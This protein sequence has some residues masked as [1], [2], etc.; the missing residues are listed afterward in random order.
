[1]KPTIILLVLLLILVNVSEIKSAL[2]LLSF[3]PSG[4]DVSVSL[5]G[6]VLIDTRVRIELNAIDSAN[7]TIDH[8][9]IDSCNATDLGNAVTNSLVEIIPQSTTQKVQRIDVQH[10]EMRRNNQS[11]GILLYDNDFMTDIHLQE[12]SIMNN[13]FELKNQ[14]YIERSVN[15]LRKY[16]DMIH[17]NLLG[18]ISGGIS[19]YMNTQIKDN[20]FEFYTTEDFL[21]CSSGTVPCINGTQGSSDLQI[22]HHIV[23]LEYKDSGVTSVLLPPINSNTILIENNLWIDKSTIGS[24]MYSNYLTINNLNDPFTMLPITD[25]V[26]IIGNQFSQLNLNTNLPQNALETFQ[27]IYAA[28]VQIGLNNIDHFDVTQNQWNNIGYYT[29]FAYQ[30]V[31]T[32]AN[33]TK[34]TVIDLFESNILIG[35]NSSHNAVFMDNVIENVF[36]TRNLFHVTN[37]RL[38][39]SSMAPLD[40]RFEMRTNTIKNVIFG[41]YAFASDI[42]ALIS[43]NSTFHINNQFN[44]LFYSNNNEQL[45]LRDNI[46]SNVTYECQYHPIPQEPMSMFLMEGNH[47]DILIDDNQYRQVKN[48]YVNNYCP[49]IQMNVDQL[50]DLST[51]IMDSNHYNLTNIFHGVQIEGINNLHNI[52]IRNDIVYVEEMENMGV[53]QIPSMYQIF[54]KEGVTQSRLTVDNNQLIFLENNNMILI[55]LLTWLPEVFKNVTGYLSDNKTA[56]FLINGAS[57]NHMNI[58]NNQIRSHQSD[59]LDLSQGMLELQDASFYAGQYVSDRVTE[60]NELSKSFIWVHLTANVND[61]YMKSNSYHSISTAVSTLPHDIHQ[62]NGKQIDS[63]IHLNGYPFI[64][65]E[66]Y[67]AE[68]KVTKEGIYSSSIVLGQPLRVSMRTGLFIAGNSTTINNLVL[69]YKPSLLME[70]INRVEVGDPLPSQ[71]LTTTPLL[72]L[73]YQSIGASIAKENPELLDTLIYDV[74]V[75]P[76]SMDMYS[77]TDECHY[78]CKNHLECNQCILT[79]DLQ[80]GTIK[81]FSPSSHGVCYGRSVFNTTDN[82]FRDCSHEKLVISAPYENQESFLIGTRNEYNNS[83]IIEP[84]V[85]GSQVQFRMND[86]LNVS[87][88]YET[89]AYNDIITGNI[90]TA[91]HPFI[92]MLANSFSPVLTLLKELQFNHIKFIMDISNDATPMINNVFFSTYIDPISTQYLQQP[93]IMDRFS[94]TNSSFEGNDLDN[95]NN[96]FAYINRYLFLFKP[97]GVG[98]APSGYTSYLTKITRFEFNDNTMDGFGSMFKQREYPSGRFFMNNNYFSRITDGVLSVVVDDTFTINDNVCVECFMN[99]GGSD[100]SILH[101]KGNALTS[102]TQCLNSTFGECHMLRNNFNTSVS[103]FDNAGATTVYRVE[104]IDGTIH[105]DDNENNRRLTYGLCYNDINSSF[106]CSFDGM[107]NLKIRNFDIVGTVKDIIC[108]KGLVTEVSCSGFEC[109]TDTTIDPETCFVNKS[110]EITNPDYGYIQFPTIQLAIDGCRAKNPK[111]IKILYDVYHETS[112]NIQFQDSYINATTHNNETLLLEG[113]S[114]PGTDLKPIIVGNNH[115]IKKTSALNNQGNGVRLNLEIQNLQ[116]INPTGLFDASPGTIGNSINRDSYILSTD[117]NTLFDDFTLNNSCFWAIQTTSTIP[118]YSPTDFQ[119]V[120]KWQELLQTEYVDKKISGVN[121]PISGV[122]TDIV[123][124]VSIK[125][126]STITNNQFYGSYSLG[127]HQY[128]G[129]STSPIALDYTVSKAF[130]TQIN[131]NVGEN[132][133]G[134]FMVLDDQYNVEY[135]STDCTYFCGAYS[136]QSDYTGVTTIDFKNAAPYPTIEISPGVP[137]TGPLYQLQLGN[138]SWV[139]EYGGGPTLNTYVPSTRL[140]FPSVTIPPNIFGGYHAAIWIKNLDVNVANVTDFKIRG[141]KTQG[142]PIALRMTDINEDIIFTYNQELPEFFNDARRFMRETQRHNNLVN[143]IGDMS[144]TIYDVRGRVP[145]ADLA[146]IQDFFCN[147]LCFPDLNQFAKCQVSINHIEGVTT[148]FG[149]TQF[150]N[151]TDAIYRCI[152][153]RIVML[154]LNHYEYI[155]VKQMNYRPDYTRIFP[156]SNELLIE[157]NTGQTTTIYGFNHHFD[158]YDDGSSMNYINKIR[159]K[160]INFQMAVNSTSPPPYN[161]LACSTSDTESNYRFSS[162]I[163]IMPSGVNGSALPMD[164]FTFE[165]VNIIFDLSDGGNE[166]VSI[167]PIINKCPIHDY[168]PHII[169]INCDHCKVRDMTLQNVQINSLVRSGFFYD[170]S[171]YDF[172]AFS[173]RLQEET[174]TTA[175]T[176]IYRPNLFNVEQQISTSMNSRKFIRLLN[177]QSLNIDGVTI[178]LCNPNPTQ[179]QIQSKDQFGKACFTLFSPKITGLDVYWLN[180]TEFEVKITNMAMGSIYLNAPDTSLVENTL[181]PYIGPNNAANNPFYFAPNGTE[182][183]VMVYSGIEWI[184]QSPLLPR[185]NGTNQPINTFGPYETFYLHSAIMN[186]TDNTISGSSSDSQI[187]IGIHLLGPNFDYIYSCTNQTNQSAQIAPIGNATSLGFRDFYFSQ[188]L[189]RILGTQNPDS[190]GIVYDVLFN[191]ALGNELGPSLTGSLTVE[192]VT[193]PTILNRL[194]DNPGDAN[195]VCYYCNDGCPGPTS[196]I[197]ILIIILTIFWCFTFICCIAF[198]GGLDRV[199]DTEGWKEPYQYYQLATK[200]DEEIKEQ[201]ERIQTL[202]LKRRIENNQIFS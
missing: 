161:G 61:V 63:L 91:Y 43:N 157:S 3:S 123:L 98:V 72:K 1:M 104:E 94:I 184:I 198:C 34:N 95:L 96:I 145:S 99:T 6:S 109:L 188:D 182:L 189:T 110:I 86:T 125:R 155:D 12:I 83:L 87:S 111:H 97:G 128:N 197:V 92:F 76:P 193:L 148:D 18:N 36:T 171:T 178:P 60:K 74:Q 176:D 147:D 64:Q 21:P 134:A 40:G 14:R 37:H 22:K 26:T 191:N 140:A 170:M 160:R 28:P 19:G 10:N 31:K 33:I 156:N 4:S 55:P 81:E 163:N 71:D 119:N 141:T 17:M 158:Q 29:L 89:F 115:V 66:L 195:S 200:D 25:R 117:P 152:F 67:M 131:N 201:N 75:E 135:D 167:V 53:T 101:I 154:D 105:I 173:M 62:L 150:S 164:S 58:T 50:N 169:G 52:T 165:D 32:L 199:W 48:N 13:T 118:S 139:V 77:G 183:Q 168:L 84:R 57:M 186:I 69:L 162:M 42:E 11:A 9:I 88:E 180:Q 8:N 106:P 121:P 39:G 107:R 56:E 120:T 103:L 16:N 15:I 65:N 181:N 38:V 85:L 194:T 73:P 47:G 136:D 146:S 35:T 124:S 177:V 153:N 190:E 7:V 144:G 20:R 80:F 46:W 70:L 24:I 90:N 192:N 100:N 174:A 116:F 127:Y 5:S 166:T 122:N 59:P 179:A 172:M 126:S 2:T 102:G 78:T 79:D 151:L 44:V 45:L 41:N 159:F 108:D 196:Y 49:M 202:R 129:V 68:N 113:C 133:W 175:M 27:E 132:Q 185:E 82:A 130:L 51:I 23:H 112:L 143:P 93:I 137:F 114:P 149:I 54:E 142:L 30:H 187:H 138:S